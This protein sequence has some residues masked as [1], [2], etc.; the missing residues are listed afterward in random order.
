MRFTNDPIE[1]NLTVGEIHKQTLWTIMRRT[2]RVVVAVIVYVVRD[3]GLW[4]VIV[5]VVAAITLA[6]S[7]HV[8][9]SSSISDSDV[10]IAIV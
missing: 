2:V 4:I 6:S 1:N 3:V 9:N 10:V 5:V 7:S 8:P